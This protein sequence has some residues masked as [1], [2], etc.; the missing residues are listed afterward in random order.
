MTSFVIWQKAQL[1]IINCE[2]IKKMKSNYDY[3]YSLM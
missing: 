3:K 2:S 1:D